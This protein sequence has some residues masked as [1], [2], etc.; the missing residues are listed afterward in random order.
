MLQQADEANEIA[1]D[2]N[3]ESQPLLAS[4]ENL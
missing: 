4:I 2:R 3:C 1:K